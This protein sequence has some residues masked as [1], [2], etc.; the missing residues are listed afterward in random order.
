[1]LMYANKVETKENKN[2]LKKKINYTTSTP[3]Y[4]IV[5]CSLLYGVSPS[6]SVPPIGTD[7]KGINSLKLQ[8]V[9][10]HSGPRS[11]DTLRQ[12]DGLTL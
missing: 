3:S 10:G 1:M 4:P 9:H 11:L 8:A 6:F 2:Y 12:K 5:M 7:K